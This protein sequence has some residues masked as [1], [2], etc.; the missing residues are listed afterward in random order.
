[1]AKI[2][3]NKIKENTINSTEVKESKTDKR[4]E[5]AIKSKELTNNA[6]EIATDNNETKQEPT[7]AIK[8]EAGNKVIIRYI[9]SGIW[10]DSDGK[11]WASENKSDNILNERQ[12][13]ISEYNKRDDIKFMV[14]YGAM[15]E[16]HVE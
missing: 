12:Y 10:K 5:T 7:K 9:G 4:T 16:T 14:K 1:M 6:S 8:A 11:F 2:D 3:M 15:K 13:S